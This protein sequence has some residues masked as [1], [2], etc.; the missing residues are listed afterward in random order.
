MKGLLNEKQ[1]S[2]Q[3][4]MTGKGTRFDYILRETES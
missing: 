1:K 2:L 3:K 4:N